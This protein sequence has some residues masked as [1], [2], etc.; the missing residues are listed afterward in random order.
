MSQRLSNALE[1]LF[2]K[3]ADRDKKPI[4]KPR[5]RRES[6]CAWIQAELRGFARTGRTFMQD[7]RRSILLVGAMLALLMGGCLS[8]GRNQS[9]R[10][11]GPSSFGLD[12][13][14]KQSEPP[15]ESVADSDKPA[16]RA[17]TAPKPKIANLDGDTADSSSLTSGKNG[18]KLVSWMANRDKEPAPRKLPLSSRTD[19]APEDEQ[20]EQ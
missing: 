11:G 1:S 13:V 14:P 4:L 18:N 7:C 5:S 19:P 17:V 2:P 6:G 8:S 10:S 3:F 20:L 9:S 16:S 15:V 12:Y